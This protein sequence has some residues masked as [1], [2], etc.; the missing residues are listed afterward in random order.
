MM[1]TQCRRL[2]LNACWVCLVL[3]IL[4]SVS[5]FLLCFTQLIKISSLNFSIGKFTLLSSE[6]CANCFSDRM[7]NTSA[8]SLWSF[9][10][11]ICY[12]VV[13]LTCIGAVLSRNLTVSATT[14]SSWI[15]AISYATSNAPEFVLSTILRS[16]LLA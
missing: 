14:A 9:M 3:K 11:T 8:T 1:K 10:F 12:D 4:V 2:R 15:L 16:L 13:T 7:S 6:H 5:S